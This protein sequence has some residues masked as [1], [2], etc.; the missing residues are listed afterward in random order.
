MPIYSKGNAVGIGLVY[1]SNLFS[2][3]TGL[4]IRIYING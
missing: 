3:S 2:D 1:R 4:A